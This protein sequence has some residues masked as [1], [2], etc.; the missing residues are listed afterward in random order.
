VDFGF[1]MND[2]WSARVA[3]T[4]EEYEDEARQRQAT[5]QLLQRLRALPGAGAA[6]ATTQLPIGGPRYA[7]KL[8]GREYASD[9]EY[10]QAHGLVVSDGFFE[11]LGIPVDGRGFDARDSERGLPTVVVNQS[12]ARRYYP[13]GALG[14]QLALT[15]GAHQEWRTIVGTVPDLG[16][17]RTPG[18]S[19]PEGIYLPLAQLPAAGLTLVVRTSGP[20]LN[21][22]AAARDAVR[23]IDPNLPIFNVRTIREGIDQQTWAFRVFGTLFMTFG[24]AALFLATVGLYGVMAFSVSRRTQELGVRM[25]L[26]AATADVLRMVLGQGLLQVA[27][28]IVLGVG[29]A[30]LLSTAMRALMF[31]VSPHDPTTFTGIAVVLALTGLL[32]CLVP[33]R[34]AARVDPME[35]LRVQ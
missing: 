16:M 15:T 2:V 17:G 11:A 5:E 20:P 25:A 26:G 8:P 10:H 27:I 29:L 9:R 21:L 18:D 14:Q 12:F 7:V 31:D 19:L 24:F 23:A 3:L 30:A 6:A 1:A 35:A 4:G 28:G 13:E 22:T 33:A 32:A 34:R